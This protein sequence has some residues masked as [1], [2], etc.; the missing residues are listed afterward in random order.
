ML[1]DIPEKDDDQ[2]VWDDNQGFWEKV[3]QAG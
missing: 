3:N 2:E 1:Q